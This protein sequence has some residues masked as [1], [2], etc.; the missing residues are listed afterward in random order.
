MD[1]EN[2]PIDGL[3]FLGMAAIMDPP[4]ED[5]ALAIQQ[6]KTAGIKVYMVTGDHPSTAAAIARQV[7]LIGSTESVWFFF[8]NDRLRIYCVKV[9]GHRRH[10]NVSVVEADD[11]DWAIVH[12]ESLAEMTQKQWDTL[13]ETPYI[14]FSRTTPELKLLI[15][16]NC[17]KRGEIVAVTGDGVNDA[18]ALKRA[19]IGV[20]MGITGK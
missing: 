3:T 17:Q 7:G 12:G 16:E 2:Y 11:K 4:R 20:A 19:D 8:T 9:R 6:C 18:P 13:L 14:V 5:A 15:V 1:E 10:M